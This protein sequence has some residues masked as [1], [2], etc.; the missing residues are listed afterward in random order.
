MNY[1]STRDPNAQLY[2][3]A[4]AIIQGLAPDGGLFV[5]AAFPQPQFDLTRLTT[6][7]YQQLAQTVLQWFF[8]YLPTAATVPAA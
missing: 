7:S 1:R 4:Q 5:P 3:D 2:T 8:P 6:S